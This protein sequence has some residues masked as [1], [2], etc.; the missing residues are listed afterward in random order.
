[1]QNKT[2]LLLTHL[3]KCFSSLLFSRCLDHVKIYTWHLFDNFL[4]WRKHTTPTLDQLLQELKRRFTTWAIKVFLFFGV[5]E[6]CSQCQWSVLWWC[7][8]FLLVRGVLECPENFEENKAFLCRQ[9]HRETYLL[10]SFAQQVWTTGSILLLVS[11][12]RLSSSRPFAFPA[13]STEQHKENRVKIELGFHCKTWQQGRLSASKPRAHSP[14]T[15]FWVSC[16]FVLLSSSSLS[17]Y[18][19]WDC[20]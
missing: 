14:I 6:S 2:N 9:W 7:V 3:H 1:M 18:P 13:P 17:I 19:C 12:W 15:S 8:G 16:F 11:S 20:K 10:K 5:M 4:A